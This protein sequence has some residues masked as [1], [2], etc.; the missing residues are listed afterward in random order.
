M[1][2]TQANFFPSIS[3]RDVRHKVRGIGQWLT[4]VHFLGEMMEQIFN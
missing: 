1:D 3:R 2:L 4:P